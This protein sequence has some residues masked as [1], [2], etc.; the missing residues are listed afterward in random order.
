MN[1]DLINIQ[2]KDEIKNTI[3]NY[4]N[5]LRVEY[6]D[7]RYYKKEMPEN[8]KLPEKFKYPNLYSDSEAGKFLYL[9]SVT[10]YLNYV[11]EPGLNQWR[12]EVG[13]EYA[14]YKMNKA[15]NLGSDIHNAIN[16]RCNGYDVIFS[17]PKHETFSEA[18]I[19]QYAQEVNSKIFIIDNQDIAVQLARFERIIQS[20][21]AEILDSEK[22]VYSLKYLYAGT[23]DLTIELKNDVEY[24]SGRE[25]LNLKKGIYIVDFKTGK[26]INEVKFFAQLGAYA[27]ALGIRKKFQ[28]ALIFHLNANIK[29]GIEGTKIYY[30]NK[31]ELQGY[32]RYFR[33]IQEAFLFQLKDFKI[34]NYEIPIIFNSQLQTKTGEN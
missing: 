18:S 24:R 1:D 30:K 27:N 17:N 11:N 6:F 5:S 29:S 16:Y 23:L 20:L 31:K 9:P 33:H 10:T 7:D 28:G 14:N 2:T 12:G 13:N 3:I 15:A 32:F 22:T 25:V 34:V 8:Y 19:K 26:N 4:T 21:G